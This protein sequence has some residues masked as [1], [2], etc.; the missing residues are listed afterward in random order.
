MPA[1]AFTDFS[2]HIAPMDDGGTDVTIF[3][4]LDLATIDEFNKAIDSV[5]HQPGPVVIDMRACPFVDSSGIAALVKATLRLRDQ[6]R[7]LRLRGVRERVRRTLDLTGVTSSE[8]LVL[9][10]E[11]PPA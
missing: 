7:A 4:E 1:E 6:K 3:G 2:I 9:E 5:L 11:T 8:L 10:P